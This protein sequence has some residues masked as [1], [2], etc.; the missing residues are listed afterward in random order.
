MAANR[1]ESVLVGSVEDINSDLNGECFIAGAEGEPETYVVNNLVY[2]PTD[3]PAATDTTKGTKQI[4]ADDQ[5]VAFI[6]ANTRACLVNGRSEDNAVRIAFLRFLAARMGLMSPHFT[7][8]ANNVRYNHAIWA[9]RDTKGYLKPAE[10]V[11]EDA[12]ARKAIKE[13]LTL[14]VRKQMMPKLTNLV[15]CV[16]YMFRVRGHH[17]MA[18]FQDRYVTLWS[19]CLYKPEDLPLEWELVATD[20]LH[21]IM[22]GHLDDFWVNSAAEAKCAGTLIKRIDSAPAGSAGVQALGRG[23][24]DVMMTFPGIVKKVPDAYKEFKTVESKVE[25]NRW[26]GSINA[27]FYGASRLRVDEGKIGALA[28]VVLGVYE[29]MA[30]NSPLRNSMALK[31]LAE[32]APA[33]GGAIGMAAARTIRDERMNLIEDTGSSIVEITEVK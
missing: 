14:A 26:G 28:S 32:I 24:T 16:A 15:C 12:H 4:I 3:F 5:M 23:L 8:T 22:P 25:G 18:D 21:A 13:K 29:H 30:P 10:P 7:V 17:Y 33:T 1:D 9:D 27:R 19:R 2:F 6:I 11:A 31:R 20:A